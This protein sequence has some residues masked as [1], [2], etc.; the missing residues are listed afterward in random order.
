MQQLFLT[1][2]KHTKNHVTQFENTSPVSDRRAA[3]L[4]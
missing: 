2:G 1:V 3:Q 4:F